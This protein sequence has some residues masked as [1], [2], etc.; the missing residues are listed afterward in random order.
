MICLVVV[1]SCVSLAVAEAVLPNVI[2]YGKDGFGHQ[3]EGL[4]GIIAMH[5]VGKVNY[6]FDYP[7][8]FKF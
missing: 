6:V 7:R 2:Q 8:T 3:L 1:W 4:M 5:V